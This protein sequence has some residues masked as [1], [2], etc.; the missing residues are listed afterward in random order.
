MPQSLSSLLVH[1]IFSTKRREPLITAEI[2]SELHK[3]MATVF[4][5]LKS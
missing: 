1:L 4:S 3:Y 2:E 5:S